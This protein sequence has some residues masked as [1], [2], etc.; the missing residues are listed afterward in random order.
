MGHMR[1]VSD[2]ERRHRL[3]RRHALAPGH[4]AA[5]PV[6]ATR[7]MTVLHATEAADRLPLAVGAGRRAHRR[8]RRPGAVRRPQPGQAARD[9]AHPVRLPARPAAR[10]VGERLGPGRGRAPGPAGQGRRGGR[11]SP[12]TARPGSTPPSSPTLAQ[13]ADGAEHSAQELREQVPELAGRIEIVARQGLRRQLP[14]RPAGADPARRRGQDRARPATPAAGGPPGRSGP[15]WRRW[16]RRELPEPAKER[17]GYAE[18]VRR[19]LASFGPGTET[20]LVWWLGS[21]KTAV[22]AALADV[23]AVEVG[24]DGG[25]DGLGAARRCRAGSPPWSPGRRCCRCSTRP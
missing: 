5:D 9:A 11:A 20:D 6:A 19:W 2:V 24:L 21:T 22:R 3:A 10:G 13:L 7:A 18:L 16:L 1:Q 8:R 17:E 15:R 23:A 4:R 25:G 14:D 12:P